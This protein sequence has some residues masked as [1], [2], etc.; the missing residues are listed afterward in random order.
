MPKNPKIILYFIYKHPL[1]LNKYGL[2]SKVITVYYGSIRKYTVYFYLKFINTRIS[3]NV[4]TNICQ[5][6]R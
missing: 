6:S 3:L 1:S 5:L 2:L 4:T